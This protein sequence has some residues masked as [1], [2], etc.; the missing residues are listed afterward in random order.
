[1]VGLTFAIVSTI[2]NQTIQNPDVFVGILNSF[3][4]NGSLLYRFKIVGLNRGVLERGVV[5]RTA[6]CAIVK[7]YTTGKTMVTPIGR[8]C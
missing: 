2:K 1:M 5:L 6:V 4:Q 8:I 7:W 3:V